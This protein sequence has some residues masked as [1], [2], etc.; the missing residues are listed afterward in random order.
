MKCNL[1]RNTDCRI[2]ATPPQILLYVV[3]RAVVTF[4][5]FVGISSTS[6]G[7]GKTDRRDRPAPR[8]LL[9]AR[10]IVDKTNNTAELDIILELKRRVE[11]VR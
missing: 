10:I 9:S 6:I 5:R 1:P 8:W 2:L 4:Y 7:R 3:E 11:D